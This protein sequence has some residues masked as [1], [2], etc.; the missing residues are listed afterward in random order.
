VQKRL[1]FDYTIVSREEGK[2]KKGKRERKL[3]GPNEVTAVFRNS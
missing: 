2:V 1:M 3:S